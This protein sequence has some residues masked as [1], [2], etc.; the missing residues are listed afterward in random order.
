MTVLDDS[1]NIEGFRIDGIAV[2]V[3]GGELDAA[4]ARSLRAA[5]ERLDPDDHVYVDCAGVGF[6]DPSGLR[7]LH[8]LADRN[9]AAGCPLHL[10]ASAEVRRSIE[11]S[12]L[13]HLF[14]L[15]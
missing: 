9:V 8:D 10:I 13:E 2:F 7:V 4:A 6:I 1:L 11:I 12:G 15:D 5:I 3:V 14:A